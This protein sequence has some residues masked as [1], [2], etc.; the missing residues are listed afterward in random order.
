MIEFKA[1]KEPEGGG[2]GPVDDVLISTF[3]DLQSL[4]NAL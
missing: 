2:G 3:L 1:I 4:C